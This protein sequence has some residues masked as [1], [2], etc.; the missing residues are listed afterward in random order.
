MAFVALLSQNT[1]KLDAV[2]TPDSVFY[3]DSARNLLKGNGL[4]NSMAELHGLAETDSKL[5]QPMTQWAPLYPALIA[6]TSLFGGTEPLRALLLS[7]AFLFAVLLMA[8]FLVA[9]LYDPWTA[10]VSTALLLHTPPLLLASRAAWS[11]TTGIALALASLWVMCWARDR[12]EGGRRAFL[13]AGLASGLVA[14]LAVTARYALTPLAA[15]GLLFCLDSKSK[16]VT[17]A[18]A[19]GF[20]LGFSLLAGPVFGRNLYYSGRLGGTPWGSGGAEIFE[21]L[22]RLPQALMAM[23]LPEHFLA[24]A[25]YLILIATLVGVAGF[26]ALRG[27]VAES[28]KR[29]DLRGNRGLLLLWPAAYTVFLVY[30]QAR[31]RIDPIDARLILP[32]SI[33]LFALLVASALRFLTDRR[34]VLAPVAFL[35][36][37]AAIHSEASAYSLTR[38]LSKLVPIHDF[39]TKRVRSETL[40]WLN[41]NRGENALLVVERGIDYPLYLGTTH[42]AFFSK[43]RTPGKALDYNTLKRFLTA[44]NRCAAYGK[45]LLVIP[46]RGHDVFERSEESGQFVADLAGANLAAYPAIA[47]V[48][49]LEDGAVY[50]IACEQLVDS[51]P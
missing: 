40:D 25:T 15:V 34:S 6:G 23:A 7:T 41:E 32:A 26:R 5:P 19:T 22:G 30:A 46:A 45:I 31:V 17:L 8:Y 51:A 29:A 13:T 48:A 33:V 35:V 18:R 12:N 2:F 42:V 16:E 3:I 9:R 10:L 49:Q 11:E 36:L 47:S 4:V 24:R 20:T 50:E 44:G 1:L 21:G 28:V 14:G 38:G 37:A 27:G 43:L 39:N